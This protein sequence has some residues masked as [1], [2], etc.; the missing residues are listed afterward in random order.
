MRR[1]LFIIL[2]MLWSGL[3]ISLMNESKDETRN[4]SQPFKGKSLGLTDKNRLKDKG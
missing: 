2:L 1:L 4:K 3:A